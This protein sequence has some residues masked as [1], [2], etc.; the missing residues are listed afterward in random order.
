MIDSITSDK[1]KKAK[2]YIFFL[3]KL[4]IS[5]SLIYLLISKVGS[6][7]ILKNMGLL[8][9]FIFIGSIFLYICSIYLSSL[10]WKLLIPKALK[11]KR[12]FSMYMIGSFFNTCM[13]G[14]IGGDTVKAYY[15]NR[16]LKSSQRSTNIK[17]T[18][19]ESLII[20][21]A[22]VFIDRYIGLFA[23][24]FIG[25]VSLPFGIYYIDGTPLKWFI[26]IAFGAFVIGTI[27]IFTFRIGKGIKFF[28]GIYEY[29][30]IY[31]KEYGK[32]LKA[33]LYSIG[34]QI[35]NIISV[36]ILSKGLSINIP[37]LS[38]FIF[39]PIIT[40]ISVIPISISGIGLREG[41]FAFLLGHLGI[42]SDVSVTLSLLWFLSIVV[43]SIGGLTEYL[44]Y[45]KQPPI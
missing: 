29:F 41:A 4:S 26:P 14:I 43:A 28:F 5:A 35:L 12:L 39:I 37:L 22:S 18:P 3:V 45:K 15:L 8:N 32:L 25:L 16:E 2:Q 6:K 36:F 23:L 38:L 10:R 31:K 44:R 33:F 17:G 24:L 1:S 7:N 30:N 11:I 27:A 34:I 42:S 13:P 19:P 21:I 9:P 20:A 40:I